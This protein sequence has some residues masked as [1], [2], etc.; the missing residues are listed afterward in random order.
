MAMSKLVLIDGY[1][2]L[3]R[4]FFAIRNLT[5]SDGTPVGALYGFTRMLIK[6]ITEIE[7]T[8][9][10]VVFDTGEKTFRNEM[11]ADYKAN[12]PPCPPDL[13]PQFP[14]V[15]EIVKVLNIA[16]LEKVGYEADD[17]IATYTKLA[18]KNGLD[19][20]VVSSDKDLMQLVDDRVQMFDGMKNEI[21]DI[22]K[23]KEK[24]GVEPKQILDLLSLMGDSADNVP[25]VP[26][27]GPK[28][29]AELINTFGS[30]DNL[31]K[32][33]DEIK[34]EKRRQVL[35]D[36][37]DNAFL[38]KKLITLD[39]NVEVPYSIDDLSFRQYDYRKLLDFLK[40]QEFNSMVKG[41]EKAFNSIDPSLLS[42]STSKEEKPNQEIIEYTTKITNLKELPE[43]LEKLNS[44]D[45]LY[46]NILTKALDYKSDIVSITFSGS[47]KNVY[48][49]EISDSNDLFNNDP[50]IFNS[51]DVLPY[52]R[53]IFANKNILKIGY[54]IKRQIK[55]LQNYNIILNNFEDIEV[56]NYILYAGLYNSMLST[57]I[58]I[59]INS[60]IF[61]NLKNTRLSMDDKIAII[62]KMEREYKKD[63]ILEYLEEISLFIL[64]SIKSVYHILKNELAHSD[65]NEVYENV[66]KP[67]TA[68]LASME[69][70]GIKID[71]KRLKS[72]SNEFEN[73]A[74]NLA[75]EIFTIADT[76]FNIGSPKQL[77]DVLFN[78]MKLK[79]I[80]K[81]SR[82]GN[83]STDVDTLEELA[84]QGCEIC[85]KILDWRHYT[86]LKNTYTD[87]MPKLADKNSRIHTTYSNTYVI[88]GRLSSSNPNLQ[89][90]PIRTE[91]G[92]KIRSAFIAKEACKLVSADYKQAE[93]R[94]LANYQN[95]VKL[96]EFFLAGKDIHKMTASEVFKVPESEVSKDMRSLAK[97]INFSII[98]GTS[99]YGLAKRTNTSNIEAKE[100]LDNYFK[101]YP[102]IKEYIDS[103]KDFVAKN[104]YV[105]TMFGRKINID[106]K[107][108]RPMVKG[109]LERL[110]IN[111]PIQG[112]ASDIVK[113]VMIELDK[114]LQTFRSKMIL[115]IHDELVLETPEDEVLTVMNLLKNTMEDI[116]KWDVKMEVDVGYGDN[117]ESIK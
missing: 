36:N 97:A 2:F 26:G 98:Y 57:I 37:R 78:K 45:K 39:E 72:L 90:I 20:M 112:T 5:R 59:N 34:Q 91:S 108:A 1:S 102:E 64:D 42:Y 94:I 85:E 55:I 115:Q 116:V 68:V 86:K 70:E 11:Y 14:L 101:T 50:N 113:K 33:L 92:S 80:K 65:L 109:M 43:I 74:N 46:F 61:S 95:V 25:G 88:S 15:R 53:N 52:F 87:V 44:D 13:I 100:Y 117:L 6:I 54:D 77:G 4:A 99:A 110:A 22:E 30:L 76:E 35:A 29:A 51:N 12:R 40:Q 82:S 107:N 38:S 71:I 83:Y 41:L 7:Y 114:K 66:E 48:F 18:E 79:P 16:V 81:A 24:W 27:I 47:G 62:E 60:I 69:I 28:T 105:K 67:M 21:I 19:V 31:Y 106:V 10:A 89:N 8:H 58:S 96:K 56:M 3:F 103:T 49:I 9:I 63:D 32:H 104:N 111:A 73:N 93:L 75:K 23:V 84:S 17:L